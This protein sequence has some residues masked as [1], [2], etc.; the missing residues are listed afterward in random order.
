MLIDFAKERNNRLLMKELGWPDNLNVQEPLPPE[1]IGWDLQKSSEGFLRYYSE[2]YDVTIGRIHNYKT[3]MSCHGKF[4]FYDF[5]IEYLAL[6][7]EAGE[8]CSDF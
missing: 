7:I 4:T 1:K 5:D 2:K 6:A 8:I 3:Y